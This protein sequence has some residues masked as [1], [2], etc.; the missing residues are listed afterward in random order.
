M[1]KI[2][3]IY[4]CGMILWN[5]NKVDIINEIKMGSLFVEGIGI[6]F[7][8]FLFGLLIIFVCIEMILNIG[9]NISDN[10][11]VRKNFIIILKEISIWVFILI[12]S[13][14]YYK[15]LI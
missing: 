14:N 10:K 4:D 13:Y 15:L 3:I 11:I 5:K 9:V 12:K 1:S 8:F 2:G 7:I 6:L